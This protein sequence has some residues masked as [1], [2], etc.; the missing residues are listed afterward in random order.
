MKKL[1]RAYLATILVF[2]LVP[3]IAAGKKNTNALT[4]V[5]QAD[6]IAQFVKPLLPYRIDAGENFKGA[7]WIKS[8]D[9][10]Q[11]K[12][13]RIFFSTHIFG[14]DIKYVTKVQKREISLEL[15]GVNLQNN[16]QTSLRYDESTKTQ[17]F[18]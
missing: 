2:L 5:I 4:L 11:I 15:G 6:S 7:M 18:S 10:I 9:N 8:V 1:R 12:G 16:W 17:W 13:N 14:K 3:A